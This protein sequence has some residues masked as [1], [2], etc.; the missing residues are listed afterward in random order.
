MKKINL[1]DGT[2]IYCLKE[3]EAVVLDEH[4]NGYLEFGHKYKVETLLLM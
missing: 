4:I 3:T 2:K 1:K